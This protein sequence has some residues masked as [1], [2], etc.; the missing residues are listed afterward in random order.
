MEDNPAHSSQI[1]LQENIPLTENEIQEAEKGL[2]VGMKIATITIAVTTVFLGVIAVLC[3]TKE[4]LSKL[5]YYDYISFALVGLLMFCFCYLIALLADRYNKHNWKKDKLNGKNRL[6]SVV[7]DRDKTEHAEY[8]TFSGPLEN[9]K[10]R[11]EVKQE[12]Y[13]RFQIGSKVMVT[14]LKFSKKALE[15][16]D[17]KKSDLK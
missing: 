10:V 3:T 12:Y 6:I 2:N 8:L 13:N 7:I 11:I 5:K 17:L 1:E 4:N 16:T 9:E 14:Y 15:I